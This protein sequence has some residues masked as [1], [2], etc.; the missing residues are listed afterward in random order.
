MKQKQLIFCMGL[1]AIALLTS[2]NEREF[3]FPSEGSKETEKGTLVLNLNASTNF[4][5]TRAVDEDDYG[6]V[7]NYNVKVLTSDGKEKLSCKGSELSSKLPL[8]LGIGSY[9]VEASYGQ[10]R[11]K[12]RDEFYMY[13][14]DVVTVKSNA[15]ETVNVECT[16]TCGKVS[17]T[18]DDEMAEL[19]TEYYVSFD[20]TT[21]KG[22]ETFDWA[23]VDKDPWYIYLDKGDNTINYTIHLT[24]KD[25]Y[26]AEIGNEKV[27]TGKVTGSFSLQRN[28]GHNLDIRPN[29]IPS[30]GG[31]MKLTITI[32]G[33]T[34]NHPITW[35]VPSS[36]TN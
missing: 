36:W 4:D 34:N 35:E 10:E 27:N 30:T 19:F 22:K 3:E 14:K 23:K 6:N 12:S 11:T 32:D 2:C 29:Y 7:Q 15:Q 8:T 1:S 17:V 31:G 21:T 20:L 28:E 33:G 26:L 25:D 9:T 18:F 13:G 16:P 5:Q 24:A